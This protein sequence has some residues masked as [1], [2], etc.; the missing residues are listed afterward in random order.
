MNRSLSTSTS[1]RDARH[2][3]ADR[4]AIVEAQV[5]PLQVRVDLH[6]QVEHDPLPGQLHHPGLQV[7]EQRSRRRAR[8]GTPPRCRSARPV[9]RWRCSGRWPACIRYGCASCSTALGD[10][11]DER[12]R[13]LRPV[14]PQVSQQPPHQPAVVGLADDVF[15]VCDMGRSVP[16][17]PAQSGTAGL[18]SRSAWPSALLGPCSTSGLHDAS[19]SSSSSCLLMQLRVHAAERDQLVVRARARRCGRRP[20]R[21]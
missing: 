4:V 8:A 11:R 20:A 14:R 15:V 9:S 16:S 1:R 2:Q 21:R 18:R 5:E 17:W 13:D 3:P 7:L 6:P 12:Q 19:S 10:D